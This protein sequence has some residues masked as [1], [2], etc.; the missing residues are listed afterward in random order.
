MAIRYILN[1]KCFTYKLEVIPVNHNFKKEGEKQSKQQLHNRNLTCT[2]EC[3]CD[4]LPRNTP[5]NVNR[6]NGY[7]FVINVHKQTMSFGGLESSKNT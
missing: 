7:L 1:T 2:V 6:A 5:M 4:I 3:C